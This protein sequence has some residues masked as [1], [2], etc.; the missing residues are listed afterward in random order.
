MQKK[1]LVDTINEIVKSKG[2]TPGQ[3]ALAW[4]II[5]NNFIVPIPGTT[6]EKHLDENVAALNIKITEEE[7]SSI[8][9]LLPKGIVSGSRYPESMMNLLNG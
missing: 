4:V 7:L 5:Q 2:V 1:K 3:L 9:K 6:K 8:N